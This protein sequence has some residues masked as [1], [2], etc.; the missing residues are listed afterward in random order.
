MNKINQNNN[1]QKDFNKKISI[2]YNE[3]IKMK[4]DLE[5]FDKWAREISLIRSTGI[6]FHIKSI[7][8]PIT[9]KCLSD[10]AEKIKLRF[11][12]NFDELIPSIMSDEIDKLLKETLEDGN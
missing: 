9:T 10:F 11:Y 3:Y 1:N 5:D 6:P 2:P 4:K 8:D 7:Y 12:Y